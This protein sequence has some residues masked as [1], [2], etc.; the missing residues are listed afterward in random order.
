MRRRNAFKV[1]GT[2][3]A[4]AAFGGTAAGCGAFTKPTE[5]G[6]RVVA[7]FLKAGYDK[8][9]YQNYNLIRNAAE[10]DIKEIFVD[11]FPHLA[12]FVWVENS[13]PEFILKKV[14]YFNAMHLVAE[15]SSIRSEVDASKVVLHKRGIIQV[16]Q[17]ALT[18]F[19]DDIA[20]IPSSEPRKL[21]YELHKPDSEWL[22]NLYF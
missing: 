20:D 10:T 4:T 9:T 3:A 15:G 7:D 6:A 2:I 8:K 17:E 22:I 18:L 21:A 1:I 13:R 16:P 19:I 12:K 11:K 5:K 14:K